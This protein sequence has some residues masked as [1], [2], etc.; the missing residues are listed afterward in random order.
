MST[1][2]DVTY[3]LLAPTNGATAVTRAMFLQYMKHLP[4]TSF[5]G[6]LTALAAGMRTT[7]QV[8]LSSLQRRDYNPDHHVLAVSG[9]RDEVEVAMPVLQQR[10]LT[11]SNNL[12]RYERTPAATPPTCQRICIQVEA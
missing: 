11:V 5:F 2:Q 1:R 12:A 9:R 3:L 7:L 8:D 10:L 6:D 4:S